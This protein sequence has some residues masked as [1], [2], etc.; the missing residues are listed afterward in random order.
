MQ[1]TLKT[2]LRRVQDFPG[3]VIRAVRGDLES[4]SPEI[5][6]DLAPNPNYRA[7]CSCCGGKGRIHDVLAERSW[8]FVPL[9][10]IPVTLHYRRRRVVCPTTGAPTVEAVPWGEGKSPYSTAM[11][12]FLSGWAKHLSW[13]QVARS[14]K[15]SWDAV[16]RSVKWAVGY[17]LEHRDLEGVT[18]IGVDEMHRG[19]GMKGENFVTMVYQIDKGKERLLWVG[20]RRTKASF[21]KGLRELEKHQKGFLRGIKVVC[22]D[23]W[24]AYLSVIAECCGQAL[25]VLD[26]FHIAKHM[27]EAVD[28]VRRG[29]QSRLRGETKRQAAK[30]SRFLFLKR[31]ARVLGK[32]RLR[33]EAARK[34][35]RQTSRAWELKESFRHFW[36][37]R[38]PTWA[39]KFLR[40]WTSMAMRSRIEPM[41]RVARMLRT[42]EDLLLN[43]FRAKRQYSSAVV[44]GMNNRTRVS[45]ASSYGHRSYEVLELTLYH[46]LGALPEPPVKHRFC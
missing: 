18:A 40:A 38:N 6:V 13:S 19:K 37:Y 22:S 5:H 23:M 7:R 12:H 3:F 17:G 9:W 31:K 10:N 34:V 2:I 42:H 21:R 41:K 27:N 29:E 14:F 24:K 33:L 4:A 28:K 35:L 16:H 39:L 20:K 46:R 26:P 36:S 1:L 44:E 45:L 30:R 8:H 25:N 15:S 32:A 11:K 43:Y